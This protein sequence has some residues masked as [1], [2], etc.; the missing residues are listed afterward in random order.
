MNGLTLPA[1]P[2]A[3]GADHLHVRRI[4]QPKGP[5]NETRA[6]TPH[7][8]SSAS[9]P[10]T[11]CPSTKNPGLRPTLT[12]AVTA[13]FS[14]PTVLNRAPPRTAKR[15]YGQSSAHRQMRPRAARRTTCRSSRHRR[16][17]IPSAAR[18]S[19]QR[20]MHLRGAPD[21]AAASP[22]HRPAPRSRSRRGSE[23]GRLPDRPGHRQHPRSK[24]KP[25]CDWPPSR[26]SAR[27]SR[28]EGG[29]ATLPTLGAQRA[30]HVLHRRTRMH[31]G[32]QRVH[33]RDAELRSGK[34][35]EAVCRL[36]H[37]LGRAAP[38]L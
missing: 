3:R 30:T 37:L 6:A 1:D 16:R 5:Q 20:R 23:R 17:A 27:S 28:S 7:P 21:A 10:R 31:P 22:R 11:R 26:S 13:R 12:P 2:A 32:H 38:L 36:V 29:S 8:C 18:P 14:L 33:E 25:C 15:F 35:N 24:S 19:N 34:T 4:A 9:P